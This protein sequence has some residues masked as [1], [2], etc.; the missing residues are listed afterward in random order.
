MLT[1]AVRSLL[2]RNGCGGEEGLF[3]LRVHLYLRPMFKLHLLVSLVDL[4]IQPE[5]ERL[6]DDAVDQVDEELTW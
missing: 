2:T 3:Y 5:L 6:A 4:L 1:N